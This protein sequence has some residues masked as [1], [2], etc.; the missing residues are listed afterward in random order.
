M[1]TT[2]IL[3]ITIALLAW[4]WIGSLNHLRRLRN[5]IAQAS[6]NLD[7]FYKQR[8]DLVPDLVATAKRYMVHETAMLDKVLAARERIS[9]AAGHEE[10]G[11][12]LSGLRIE[13][14]NYPML[15]SDAVFCDLMRSLNSLELDV[16]A[17]RQAYNSS[18]RVYNDALVCFPLS[19]V[20]GTHG[21][22]LCS[23]FAAAESER[24]KK[25]AWAE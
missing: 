5:G 13:L 18:V 14:E 10:L 17:S 8:Y 25:P 3:I 19:I 11:N 2:A 21:F 22:A 24:A 6:G 1:A 4:S 7:A 20:A 16:A 9:G 12:A 15:K 23:S